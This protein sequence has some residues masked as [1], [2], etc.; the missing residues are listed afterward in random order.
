MI[1]SLRVGVL[2]YEDMKARTQAI[3]RGELRPKADDPKVWFTSLESLAL[4]ADAKP[5]SIKDLAQL[6]GRAP[7]NVSRTLKAFER[8]GLVRLVIA[9]FFYPKRADNPPS[10]GT[11][12]PVMNDAAGKQRL[13]VMCATSSGLP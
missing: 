1:K 10:T 13:S 4:I 9:A 8:Y 5:A 3:A 2:S 11:I 6:S 12:A 7:L